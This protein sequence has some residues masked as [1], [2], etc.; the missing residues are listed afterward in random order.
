LKL[1]SCIGNQF[2]LETL[3]IIYQH[4]QPDTLAHLWKA[5]EE[6]LVLSLDD[7]YK[8]MVPFGTTTYFRFQHDRIQQAAYFLID[9]LQKFQLHLQI[10]RL[11]LSSLAEGEERIFEIIDHLN[12]GVQLLHNQDEK[13]EIAQLNWR[14]GH[15][16]KAATA[17]EAAVGY[18]KMGVAQLA[19][20]SWQTRY[21]LTLNL[22]IEMVEAEYLNTN[23]A[24]T[25][26][27]SQVALQHANNLLDKIRIYEIQIQ[28]HIAQNKMLLAI[29]L[30]IEVLQLLDVSLLEFP[31][32]NLSVEQ[33]SHLPTMT[34]PIKLAAQ[35][36]LVIIFSPI[37]IVKPELLQKV[38]FTLVD[39]SLKYGNSPFAAFGY[40]F[41]GMLLT[42]YMSDIKG[43]Y[44]FGQLALMMLE[45]FEATELKCKVYN[46]IN[47]FILCWNEHARDT[48]ESLRNTIQFGLDVGDLEY[49]GYATINYCLNLFWVGEPLDFVTAKQK[50]YVK[51]L[52]KLKQ[53]YSISY[54]C[55]T[56][57]LGLNLRNLGKEP[58]HLVG[59][60]FNETEILPKWQA[61]N[62]AGSLFHIYTTK[63]ILSYFLKHYRE[64]AIFAG[65]AV[66]YQQSAVGL[67]IFAQHNFYYSLALLAQYPYINCEQQQEYLR[68]VIINQD[69]MKIWADHAPMNFQHKYDL[70]KAEKARVLKQELMAMD[71]YEKAI[72]G[73]KENQYLQEEALAYELAAEF[74][75]ARGMEKIAQTYLRE[76]YYHYQQWG[77]MVK[78]MDLEAKYPYLLT[79]SKSLSPNITATCTVMSSSATQLQTSRSL[80]L[81]SVMKA[82][83]TL[84]GEI[85]LSKLLA[86]L[87]HIVIENAG[88]E[89][90]LLLL[91]QQDNWFIEAEGHVNSMDVTLLQSIAIE[92]S[93]QVSTN[94]I[95]YVAR[96]KENVV[97]ADA[98]QEERFSQDPYIVKH[99][100]KSV[101]GMPLIN[102]GK[103]TG[104]LYLENRL[105]EGAFTP[106]RL[107]VLSMLSSQMAISIENSLLD[108]NLEQKVSERTQELSQALEHLKTTQKQLIEAE[109]MASLG[110]LVAGVAH[111]INTPVGVSFSASS[112]LE[113]ESQNFLKLYQSGSMKR[114]DLNAFLETVSESSALRCRI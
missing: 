70:V 68:L 72:A 12:L 44:Q 95:H 45:R 19:T 82:S 17:Y 85:V 107:Q 10:G 32:E 71:W 37:Y 73:A 26:I 3:S 61:T 87:M 38:A 46:L 80:D 36:I 106:Q 101:L 81:G 48:I 50:P 24:Q 21:T 2:D 111:E 16:A 43:G 58:H 114:S 93:E 83:Q 84:S 108:N 96:T 63:S 4:P 53:E 33:L 18:F 86:N 79:T 113:Q 59:E 23:F 67:F 35:R 22:H 76:A 14:A 65:Q 105:T 54:V 77:A 6:N 110:G 42:T 64:A 62:T 52:Q 57:Q 102:Q 41:Y 1:A 66:D 69:Q 88:A 109:K 112:F 100:P 103:M 13:N 27:L 89:K 20:D 51:L 28:A 5:I 34:D 49:V 55:S 56:A 11:L 15:K 74:Y 60:L 30:G 78:V 90:G 91:P 40:A 25:E 47:D 92:N 75:L 104:M 99:S 39:L 9:A 94:I 98:T 29:E 7:N 97:L 31:P 8:Q